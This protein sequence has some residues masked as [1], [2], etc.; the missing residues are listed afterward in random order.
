MTPMLRAR[1]LTKTVGST[2]VLRGV[3]LEVARGES[4]GVAGAHGSGRS[5]LLRILGTLL[6]PSSGTVEVDGINAV[7]HVHGAR[8]QLTYCGETDLQGHGLRVH[9][10]LRFR[11][12]ARQRTAGS[13]NATNEA[14]ARAGLTGDAS[15]ASLSTG[16]R[17]SLALASA[18]VG[19]PG[20]LLLDVPLNAVDPGARASLMAWLSEARRHGM[21][22]VAAVDENV[23]EAQSH[24]DRVLHLNAGHLV[25]EDSGGRSRSDTVTIPAEAH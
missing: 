10:Y 3:D 21:A 9:E 2:P 17:Y 25:A 22:I 4:V 16:M 23:L 5:T 13:R 12:T 11:L 6:P 14:L 19:Q 7:T 18:L 1:G 15:V 20:L 24:C 8:R